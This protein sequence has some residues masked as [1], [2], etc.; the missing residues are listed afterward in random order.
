MRESCVC[1]AGFAIPSDANSAKGNRRSPFDSDRCAISAQGR[2]SATLG[3]TAA[4]AVDIRGGCI[5]W[6]WFRF[7]L[8][9]ISESRCGAPM[10]VRS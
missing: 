4:F 3:M 8:P 9:H 7:V 10:I 2:L 6:G 1:E 5:K